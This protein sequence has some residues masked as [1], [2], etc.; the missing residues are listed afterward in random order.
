MAGWLAGAI[1]ILKLLWRMLQN[2][3]KVEEYDS[4]F[5]IGRL[6]CGSRKR[7]GVNDRIEGGPTGQAASTWGWW[8]TLA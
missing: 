4:W 1:S 3:W 7:P 5:Y 8:F 2:Q 6:T